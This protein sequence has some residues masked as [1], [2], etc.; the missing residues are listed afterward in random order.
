MENICVSRFFFLFFF[1][2]V[3]FFFFI[4][5]FKKILFLL[6]I[7]KRVLKTEH[8][9][10]EGKNIRNLNLDFRKQIEAHGFV[11]QNIIILCYKTVLIKI[12]MILMI[13]L[14]ETPYKDSFLKI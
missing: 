4:K 9:K 6:C 7:K 8:S 14:A 12:I 10:E 3:F 13:R 11:N 2:F 1:V 5:I